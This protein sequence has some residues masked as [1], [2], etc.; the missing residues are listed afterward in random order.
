MRVDQLQAQHSGLSFAHADHAYQ[1]NI[2]YSTVGRREGC[3]FPVPVDAPSPCRY[4]ARRGGRSLIFHIGSE[5]VWV[6]AAATRLLLYL[7]RTNSFEAQQ[8]ERRSRAAA[9]LESRTTV[10]SRSV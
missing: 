10:I 1:T 3:G 6:A 9:T 2:L 4:S 8:K 5:S 7:H